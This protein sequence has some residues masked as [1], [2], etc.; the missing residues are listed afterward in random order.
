MALIPHTLNGSVHVY[1]LPS[2]VEHEPFLRHSLEQKK[3]LGLP[4]DFSAP[5]APDL[6]TVNPDELGLRH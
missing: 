2:M 1:I 5:C 3:S 4:D 6:R